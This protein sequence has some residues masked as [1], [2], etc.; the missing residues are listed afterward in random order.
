MRIS[1]S[2]ARCSLFSFNICAVWL[3]V[4]MWLVKSCD[5]KR[6]ITTGDSDRESWTVPHVIRDRECSLNNDNEIN[7]I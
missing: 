6:T 4:D 7:D 2:V 1:F 3:G 5:K